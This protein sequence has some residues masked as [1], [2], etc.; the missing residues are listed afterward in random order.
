M[1]RKV[2]IGSLLV[3]LTLS[4]LAQQPD[5]QKQK[6]SPSQTESQKTQRPGDDEVVRITTN[7]VQVDPVITDANGKVVTDLRED[8]VEILEDGKVQKITNFSF[9]P[10]ESSK[11]SA[12]AVAKRPLDNNAPP[13]P[14]LRLRPEDV[15]R[16]IAV[17]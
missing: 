13:L 7:L 9:V 1:R 12:P 3:Q 15:R 14:P 16:T 11:P 5:P 10:F 2:L 8:E 6:E 4:V 17:V